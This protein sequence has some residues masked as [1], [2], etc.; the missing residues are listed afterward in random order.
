MLQVSCFFA[1][2]RKFEKEVVYLDGTLSDEDDLYFVK[3]LKAMQNIFCDVS[4]F[5]GR[6]YD[7]EHAIDH[8][9][10]D[11]LLAMADSL[12]TEKGVVSFSEF[13]CWNVKKYEKVC[14]YFSKISKDK[15]C[16]KWFALHGFHFVLMAFLSRY[17]YDYQQTS[18]QKLEGLRNKNTKNLVAENLLTLVKKARLEKCKHLNLAM[19]ILCKK[20]ALPIIFNKNT[21]ALRP[22]IFFSA[23]FHT[24][25]NR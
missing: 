6:N 23:T 16:N 13:Q 9:F 14:D 19:K 3:Y 12:I 4:I 1:W 18:K 5:E 10:K 25:F 2:C 7:N 21:T 17:G 20:I 15:D 11:Q 8:F 22:P 24:L